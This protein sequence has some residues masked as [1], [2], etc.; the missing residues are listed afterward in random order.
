MGTTLG[1]YLRFQDA[2]DQHVGRTVAGLDANSSQFAILPPHYIGP[3]TLMRTVLQNCFSEI[4]DD[5]NLIA[6]FAVSSV[7]YHAEY[8]KTVLS[9]DH[10]LFFTPI[11]TMPGIL[12]SLMPYI[13]CGTQSDELRATGIPPHISLLAEMKNVT[14]VLEKFG[15]L[16]ES[17]GSKIVADI[18]QVLEERAI[19]AGTVTRDGLENV[20]RSVLEDTGI[21][22]FMRQSHRP[23]IVTAT[24]DQSNNTQNV[25]TPYLWGGCFHLFPE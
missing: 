21:F 12:N 25:N 24:E 2:D 22:E 16:F 23:N 11:F 6:E 7:V 8:L 17:T 14:V 9:T 18:I 5:M 1:T 15:S 13:K 10:R 4:S 3:S 19:G 20:F